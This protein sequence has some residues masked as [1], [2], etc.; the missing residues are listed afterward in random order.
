[1][2]SSYPYEHRQN[3]HNRIHRHRKY[4]TKRL[5]FLLCLNCLICRDCYNATD[6]IFEEPPNSAKRVGMARRAGGKGK[7]K[8]SAKGEEPDK[9]AHFP[10]FPP[11]SRSVQSLSSA[12]KAVLR[13]RIR[14]HMF[15]GL[16]DPDPLVRGMDLDPAPDP[17]II[18]Q[19]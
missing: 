17:S 4:R 8:A 18:M 10:T 16:Q 13:I 15:L 12:L 3:D 1:M 9:P 2:E 14:I 7:G 11:V 5:I 19:K 6:K